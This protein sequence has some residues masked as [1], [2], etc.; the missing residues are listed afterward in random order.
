VF[1]LLYT[2]VFCSDRTHLALHHPTMQEI[3]TCMQLSLF[4]FS[5]DRTRTETLPLFDS[6]D[7][8]ANYKDFL[9][10]LALNL[11]TVEL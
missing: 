8:P 2:A 4:Q 10:D 1:K 5:P 9:A 3:L 11:A 7:V 6:D